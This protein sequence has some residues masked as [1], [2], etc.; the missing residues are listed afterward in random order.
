MQSPARHFWQL[1]VEVG[2]A[3]R[4]ALEVRTTATGENERIA[5]DARLPI[6]DRQRQRW[7]SQRAPVAFL[8]VGGRDGP[9]AVGNI[10]PF[11]FDDFFAPLPGQQQQ[12]DDPAE[13]PV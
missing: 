3:V 2:N 5:A 4:K 7:Q 10:V 13:L 9:Y 1:G 12:L 11:H 8:T 6:D